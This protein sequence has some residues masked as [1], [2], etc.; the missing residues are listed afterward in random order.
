MAGESVNKAN[1]FAF[2]L[3]LLRSRGLSP[4]ADMRPP[5]TLRYFQTGLMPL[6]ACCGLNGAQ[7]ET[8]S[9]HRNTLRKAGV[10]APPQDYVLL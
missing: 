2:V 1:K 7:Q 6:T 8:H 5:G 10:S 4:P 3:L 9:C